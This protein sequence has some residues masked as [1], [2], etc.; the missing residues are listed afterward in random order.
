MKGYQVPDIPTVNT[1]ED[2]LSLRKGRDQLQA[3]WAAPDSG[4]PFPGVLVIHEIS[5]LNDNIRTITRRLAGEG[6]VALAVDLFSGRNRAV[7]LARVFYGILI[8]PLANGTVAEVQSGLNRLRRHPKVDPER[9]GVIGFC[10]GGSYA[11]QLAC[12]DD[13]MRA[14]SV[15]YAQ[16]PRPLSALAE[17]CPIAG[18]YPGEDFTARAGAELEARLEAYE[19]EYDIKTYPGARHSFF[20]SQG[21]AY[22]AAAADDAWRRTMA[23]FE[24]HMGRSSG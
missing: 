15:F 2:A 12:V 5:G 3:F 16:N 11:L 19:V 7:C 21:G 4:G 13:E 1:Q 24:V 20:N 6:Y 10:M 8:R 22:D 9:T 23:F 14:A 17:A 18:S